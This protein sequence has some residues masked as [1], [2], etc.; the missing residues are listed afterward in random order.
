MGLREWF[1]SKRSHKSDENDGA[2]PADALADEKEAFAH[3]QAAKAIEAMSL[4][5]EDDVSPSADHKVS[6]PYDASDAEPGDLLVKESESFT[7]IN[8]VEISDVSELEDP[9]LTAS[10]EG[11]VSELVVFDTEEKGESV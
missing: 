1:T 6:A 11:D 7:H 3:L 9:Y 2:S 8:E 5:D 4:F 10:V